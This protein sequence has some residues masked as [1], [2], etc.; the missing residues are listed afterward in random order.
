MLP[1]RENYQYQVV[2]ESYYQKSGIFS[3]VNADVV[4]AV[5]LDKITYSVRFN[6]VFNEE[7]LPLAEVTFNNETK[8][9]GIDGMVE[10]Y[11]IVPN[12]IMPLIVEGVG[13]EY[14]EGEIIVESDSLF[15][16][17][18][19]KTGAHENTASHINIYPNPASESVNIKTDLEI[20]R[21][22][23]FDLSGKLIQT[24]KP[25]AGKTFI[26]MALPEQ[27]GSF[28]LRIQTQ[29]DVF[30]KQIMVNN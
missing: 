5:N 12:I 26:N 20:L 13:F 28:M 29:N 21:V 25:E 3:V 24:L 11:A 27:N 23:W 16:I 22:E 6:I 7:P 18:L 30:V 10:F 9:T 19:N 1:I 2:K 17:S 4:E 8:T 14:F 15:T